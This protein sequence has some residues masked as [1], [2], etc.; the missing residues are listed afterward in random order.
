MQ[1]PVRGETPQIDW[2]TIQL[3]DQTLVVRWTFFAQWL[4]S[5]RKVDVRQLKS[6]VVLKDPSLVDTLVE[7][8]AAAVSEN[9]TSKSLPAPDAEYWA[10]AISQASTANPDIWSEVNR[11]IWVA[12]GKVQPTTNNPATPAT[13]EETQPG[14]PN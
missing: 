11:A 5:K 12:V 1:G 14:A 13:S 6:L 10:Y 4:L 2:P 3:G 9:F 7:C 8:F